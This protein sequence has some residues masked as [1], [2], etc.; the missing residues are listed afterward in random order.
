MKIRRIIGTKDLINDKHKR[1]YL[2]GGVT[3][4][5]KVEIFLKL[6]GQILLLLMLNKTLKKKPC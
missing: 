1:G 3:L 2:P 4:Y 5:Q 6:E